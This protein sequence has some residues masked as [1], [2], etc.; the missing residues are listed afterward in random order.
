MSAGGG[1][2]QYEFNDDQSRVIV[3]LA[4]GLRIVGLLLFLFGVL[5]AVTVLTHMFGHGLKWDSRLLGPA[6]V[7]GAATLIYL[8][9]GWWFQKSSASFDAVAAT[10][11]NDVDHLMTALNELRKSFSLIRTLILVYGIFILMGM[12]A[13]LIAWY[14]HK[15]PAA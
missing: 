10:K 15:P 5:T 14:T 8:S 1:S 6:L 13:V 4:S 9:L 12:I 7:M 3:D 11:G 2:G